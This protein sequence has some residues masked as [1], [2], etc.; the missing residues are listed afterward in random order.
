MSIEI[1]ELV[2]RFKRE[3]K[4]KEKRRAAA[5]EDTKYD[6]SAKPEEEEEEEEQ[7]DLAT[8]FALE[9][10]DNDPGPS[11]KKLRNV[12]REQDGENGALVYPLSAISIPDRLR[13]RSG[14]A[15]AFAIPDEGSRHDARGDNPSPIPAS[16]HP[17][18]GAP[19]SIVDPTPYRAIRSSHKRRRRHRHRRDYSSDDSESDSDSSDFEY[20]AR[21]RHRKRSR[22]AAPSA[23]WSNAMPNSC[24]IC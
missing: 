12:P 13:A 6:P 16:D 22:K 19:S 5:P 17:R 20:R 18:A 14:Q 24:V 23:S 8:F 2:E 15:V 21:R 10:S 11:M 7:S 3:W 9:I 1:D 4:R